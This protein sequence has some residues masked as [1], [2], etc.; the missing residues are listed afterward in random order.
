M[1]VQ[2][3][4]RH[5]LRTYSSVDMKESS[6]MKA[7]LSATNA[8]LHSFTK[9]DTSISLNA[10][11]FKA[12]APLEVVLRELIPNKNYKTIFNGVQMWPKLVLVAS[13]Q[14]PCTSSH[15]INT[16]AEK[17]FKLKVLI[18]IPHRELRKNSTHR[19]LTIL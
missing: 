17:R 18:Q 19:Y 3:A 11:H 6:L 14:I 7:N 12:Y 9:T 4:K 10:P 13:H 16:L 15:L 5:L 8:K 2:L 1:N